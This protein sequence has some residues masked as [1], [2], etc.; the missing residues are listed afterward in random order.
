MA[1]QSRTQP[2]YNHVAPAQGWLGCA[3]GVNKG[4]KKHVA[5]FSGQSLGFYS[6]GSV[7]HC[8]FSSRF[9]LCPCVL[10]CLS[11]ASHVMLIF[12]SIVLECLHGHPCPSLFAYVLCMYHGLL[13]VFCVVSL[14]HVSWLIVSGLC[15]LIVFCAC[16]MA[17]CL[18]FVLCACSMAVCLG[19]CF[20]FICMVIHGHLHLLH[21]HL[22]GHLHG[23][24]IIIE[25]LRM[26]WR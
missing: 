21:G 4:W 6:W 1:Y 19:L 5:C 22:H 10:I 25:N 17:C 23:L 7:A 24:H 9:A 26:N 13:S 15:V 16:T 20:T 12:E 3:C 8:V 2:L 18:L 11:L 14:V